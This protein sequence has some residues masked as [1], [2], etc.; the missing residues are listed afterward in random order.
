M[1]ANTVVLLIQNVLTKKF[2]HYVSSQ[3]AVEL[4][5]NKLSKGI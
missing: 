4:Q 5:S 2:I 3:K 1:S